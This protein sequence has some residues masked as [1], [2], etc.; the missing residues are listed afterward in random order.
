MLWTGRKLTG[1]KL[2]AKRSPDII[3]YIV[4]YTLKRDVTHVFLFVYFSA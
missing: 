4:N 1:K 2:R 3:I